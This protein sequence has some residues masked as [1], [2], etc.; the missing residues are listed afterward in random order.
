MCALQ[1]LPGDHS[2]QLSLPPPPPPP[3][4]L[5]LCSLPIQPGMLLP[6]GRAAADAALLPHR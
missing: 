6:L 3:L 4:L 5:L 1:S 2:L